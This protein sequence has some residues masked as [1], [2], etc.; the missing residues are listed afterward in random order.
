MLCSFP[1]LIAED[2]ITQMSA[3]TLS[4]R[5]ATSKWALL[6][7]DA[8]VTEDDTDDAEKQILL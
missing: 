5:W 4:N 3:G 8:S 6:P 1:T 2:Q 7:F